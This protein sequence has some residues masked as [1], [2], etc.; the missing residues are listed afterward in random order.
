MK[1]IVTR[2]EPWSAVI[3]GSPQS[4][5]NS[6]KAVSLPRKG[7]GRRLAFIK[8]EAARAYAY[9]FGLQCPVLDPMFEQ[10]VCV[11]MV[12]Y[13][14][15]RRNDLDESLI[16]DCLQGRVYRN[17]RQVRRKIIEGRIDG[18]RPRTEI[19]ISPVKAGV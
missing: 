2:K 13:Y 8:S 11:E 17:D 5:A 15:T 14:A 9:D 6:R 7:G 19:R 12:I 16:L 4:K 10:D 1:Q 18:K 3:L